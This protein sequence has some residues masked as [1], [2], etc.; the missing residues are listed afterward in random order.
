MANAEHVA[1]LMEGVEAWNDW[2]A[3]HWH[4][5]PDLSHAN[6]LGAKLHKVNFRGAVMV[7]VHLSGADATEAHLLN[8]NLTGA[9]LIGTDLY[10]ANLTGATFCGA[11][12][13]NANFRQVTLGMTVF[14]DT[15]L[16]DARD[17]DLCTHLAPS[18][19]DYQT[20]ARS[21]RL[22]RGFLRGCG[23]SDELIDYL[24]ALMERN[25]IQFYSCFISY[26]TKDQEFAE[27][28]HSD[29][30][31]HS[32]RCWFAP[33]NVKGGRKLHE[34]IDEAIRVYDRLLLILSEHSMN[35]EWVRTEIAHARQKEIRERRQ[36]LFPVRL[37]DFETVGNWKC[38]DAD[39]GK[40]SAREVREYFIP[41]FSQ[42]KEY[43]SYW[44]AFDRLVNDLRA[45]IKP[46][47][48]RQSDEVS[49]A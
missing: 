26:S 14:G 15:D 33:H 40:D 18:I 31:K 39:T 28:L 32:V 2:R 49:P 16:R 23:V 43:D 4:V 25:P 34:Q 11:K 29:L 10:W 21:G 45:S 20:M 30:E 13:R 44:K 9:D 6:L 5:V 36:I 38:F 35:S 37:V 27:R 48:A 12:L 8:A 47:T 22:P 42:W 7:K 46:F 17:L 19:I 1:K 24:R 3:D 41:D